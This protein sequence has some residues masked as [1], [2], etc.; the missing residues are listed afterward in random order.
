MKQIIKLEITTTY[1]PNKVFVQSIQ[2]DN[3][4]STEETNM[5]DNHK[6]KSLRISIY[7]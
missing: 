6:E 7:L 5:T 1:P 3:Q 4:S 2:T